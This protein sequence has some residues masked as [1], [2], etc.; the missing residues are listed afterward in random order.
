VF[1]TQDVFA[2]TNFSIA[3]NPTANFIHIAIVNGFLDSIVLHD[4]EGKE[5]LSEKIKDKQAIIDARKLIVGIYFLKIISNRGAQ[6]KIII[7]M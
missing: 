5:I 7:K 1:F 3:P 4:L 2:T 6:T